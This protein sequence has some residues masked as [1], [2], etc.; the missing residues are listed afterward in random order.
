MRGVTSPGIVVAVI[1]QRV[2]DA[3]LHSGHALW[4]AVCSVGDGHSVNVVII[5]QVQPPPRAELV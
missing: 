3:D 1:F 5:Q 2:S 4:T